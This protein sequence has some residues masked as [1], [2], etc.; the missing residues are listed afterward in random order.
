MLT[1]SGRGSIPSVVS[2]HQITQLTTHG[3]SVSVAHNMRLGPCRTTLRTALI[4]VVQH[5]DWSVSR[6]R[7][8][9]VRLP[10]P[11]RTVDNASPPTFHLT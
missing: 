10:L 6:A 2:H 8:E 11:S 1:L 9:L 3:S 7:S 4:L 5:A